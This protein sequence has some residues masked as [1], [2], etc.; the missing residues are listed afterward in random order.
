MDAASDP[1]LFALVYQ[2][3]RE[4]ARR[5]LREGLGGASLDATGLVHEV[6]LRLAEA[7]SLRVE[8]ARHYQA[9]AARAMRWI[10]V[11]RARRRALAPRAELEDDVA[12]DP[13]AEARRLEAERTLELD[14]ALE[15]LE[16]A[17]PRA[18][19]VVQ[20]R[21][22]G[23]LSVEDTARALGLSPATVKREW[24]F[25]KAWLLRELEGDRSRTGES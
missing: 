23:G 12:A 17:H 9:V 20:Q 24:A 4:L 1:P 7:G 14:E 13:R 5:R 11:D 6:W 21:Y 22:F 16:R 18:A 2:E 19:E 3:L 8:D 15:R 10:L 25:A